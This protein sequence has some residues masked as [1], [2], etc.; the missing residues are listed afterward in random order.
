MTRRFF[1]FATKKDLLEILTEMEKTTN[2]QYIKYERYNKPDFIIH[3]SITEFEDLGISKYGEQGSP[4][5]LVMDPT[6]T[7]IS[8]AVKQTN[9]GEIKYFINSVD[10]KHSIDFSPGGFYGS[11]LLVHGEIGTMNYEDK[12]TEE[13]YK[14]FKKAFSKKCKKIHN[15]YFGKEAL[16]VAKDVRLITVGKDQPKSNDFI[17]E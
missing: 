1:F 2:V 7:V 12:K 4:M 17:I 8:E 5:Y 14:T 9:T 10:N 6:D 15:W 13:L 16:S 3:K 11:G